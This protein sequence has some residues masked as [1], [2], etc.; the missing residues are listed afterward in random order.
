MSFL[1][2]IKTSLRIMLANKGRTFLTVL[3][4]VVGIAAVVV[5]YSAGEGVSGLIFK[6]VET[7][8]TDIIETEIKVPSDK[9]GQAGETESAGALATGVQITTLT[10]DDMD[11][12]TKNS[13]NVKAAYGAIMGQEIVNYGNETRRAFLFG[14]SADYINIDKSQI[15]YGRW[16]TDSEDRTLSAVAVIGS[17]MKE[18]L[19]GDQDPLGKSI[20]IRREKFTIVG[21]MKD[22]GAVMFMDFDDYVYIPVR[23]MQKKVM[24]INHVMY[25]VHQLKNVD[26]ALDTAEEA[27]YI[28][29]AKHDITNPDK[30]DFR[31]VTMIESMATLKTVTNAITWLLLGI[32]AIS[33]IVGGVGVMNIM[34]VIVTERT[35]EIGLRK[36]VGATFHDIM[37][38]FL[39]ESTLITIL[40]GVIGIGLGLL[41][42]YGI[43]LV[44]VSFGLDWEFTVPFR[45]YVVSMLFSLVFGV[46][47]GLYPARQ[48]ARLDP[49]E[50]LR[51]E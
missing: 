28:I 7:F 2:S 21:V 37:E 3:G 29:R 43:S 14:T 33:L 18:K 50:A 45:A 31:V 13:S 22:R 1:D 40:G 38:Q 6:Q 49:I 47:F 8:G 12:V 26:L 10:L 16:F 17:K 23:T 5:V 32:V 20:N 30:D 25:M 41:M 35:A 44:A 34:Y 15:D 46:L 42:S 36:A 4:I 51:N 11:A 48:A 39:V 24:G 19:F 9:K 27:R